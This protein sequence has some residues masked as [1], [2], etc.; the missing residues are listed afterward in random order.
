MALAGPEFPVGARYAYSGIGY[1]LLAMIV[2]I[3][4]EQS[5]GNYLKANIFDPLGM[6]HSVAY[7][8]SRPAR[9]RLA[10]GYLKEN[11]KDHFERWDYPMLT[12]GDGGL[13][14]TL[15]DM[16]LW[17]QAL[18]TERLVSKS[19]LEQ[20]YRS[21]TTSD[22]TFVNYGFG[23]YTDVLPLVSAAER[24]QLLALGSSY[25]RHVAHG[26]SCVAYFNYMIRFLDVR[27]TVLVLTNAGP[28]T[29]VSQLHRGGI[30]SP[31]SRAHQVAEILF[32]G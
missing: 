23:W 26:G 6:Q 27:R 2:A 31:R 4:S 5:I 18:N 20:A 24:G 16:L 25:R 11:D 29:P 28:L 9:H 19:T 14:S 3:V 22:G 1:V 13:F 8:E 12:V 7:D 30:P 32:G 17:E 21:G 15:D 10:H